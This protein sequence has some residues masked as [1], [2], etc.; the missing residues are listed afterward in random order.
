MSKRDKMFADMTAN[1]S[2]KDV[3]TIGQKLPGMKKGPVAEVWETVQA[4]WALIKDPEAAWGAK[5]LAIGALLYLVSP[6]DAIPDV[7]P[8][9]GLTDDVAVIAAAVAALGVA[10][11]K[12]RES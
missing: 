10:L 3:A 4:M 8:V 2:T 7:I 1:A 12:Y 5:A 9:V 6:I 11:N